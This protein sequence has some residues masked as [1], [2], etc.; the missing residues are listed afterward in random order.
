MSALLQTL[1]TLFD[2][3]GTS[4]TDILVQSGQPIRIFTPSGWTN[5]GNTV[6]DED[7]SELAMQLTNCYEDTELVSMLSEKGAC[8]VGC[9][10][11]KTRI[12]VDISLMT[13]MKN[14]EIPG[15]GATVQTQTPK[16]ELC[17]RRHRDIVSLEKLNFPPQFQDLL[18]S[19]AGLVL[20]TG[21]VGTG[22]TSSCASALDF[23]NRNTQSH[24]ITI[25]DPIEYRHINDLSVFSDKEVGSDVSS[26]AKAT[27]AALRQHPEVIFI[28]E[29]RDSET[30]KQALYAAQSSLV[31]ATTHAPTLEEGIERILAFYPNEESLCYRSLRSS[32]RCV[33]SQAL[34]PS[35]NNQSFMM[36]YEYVAGANQIMQKCLTNESNLQP[37]REM[38]NKLTEANLNPAI[39]K[40][41]SPEDQKNL[42]GLVSMN[43]QL[44]KAVIDKTVDAQDALRASPDALAFNSAVMRMA[45]QQSQQPQKVMTAA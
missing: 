15:A 19:R 45:S 22:K 32:L 42:T 20:V 14:L 23:L 30:T 4:Y 3:T 18:K 28:S 13:A 38:L 21:Q 36:F 43:S 9:S 1:T 6:A 17:I 39:A 11:G 37:M 2:S 7:I 8:N 16:L 33:I 35:N 27:Y 26:F 44:V 29:L 25:Q 24:I 31:I 5:T 34:L 10:V 40:S 12:R 41:L